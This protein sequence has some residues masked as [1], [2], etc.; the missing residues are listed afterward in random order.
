MSKPSHPSPHSSYR[1]SAVCACVK[2]WRTYTSPLGS[3]RVRVKEPASP[4]ERRMRGR[5]WP[6]SGSNV[7]RRALSRGTT[8][9]PRGALWVMWHGGGELGVW[10]MQ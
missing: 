3:P 1:Y 9:A 10:I 8:G 6:L 7:G 2:P 5:W 4:V